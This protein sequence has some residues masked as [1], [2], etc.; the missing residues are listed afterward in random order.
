MT[1]TELR[2]QL[3]Q[4]GLAD[5]AKLP[6][7]RPEGR[8]GY[9]AQFRWMTVLME[10]DA[11]MALCGALADRR[12]C[13]VFVLWVLA[14]GLAGIERERD[15][16]ENRRFLREEHDQRFVDPEYRK[17][18]ESKEPT[19]RTADEAK[20]LELLAKTEVR[21]ATIVA[22]IAKR[23]R[24]IDLKEDWQRTEDDERFLKSLEHDPPP[25]F[26]WDLPAGRPT[27]RAKMVMVERL[28]QHFKLIQY[29]GKPAPLLETA[30]LFATVSRL[31][32]LLGKPDTNF[33]KAVSKF[34]DRIKQTD[35]LPE[36][37]PQRYSTLKGLDGFLEQTASEFWSF[38]Q[39][40]D[41]GLTNFPPPHP[42][43]RK[44]IQTITST[45]S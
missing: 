17:M 38:V 7:R 32:D 20:F 6:D 37:D 19:E 21:M 12:A 11:I 30:R 36:I 42:F 22:T 44:Y 27:Q 1:P 14:M 15:T 33:Q 43:T 8:V 45:S 25:P 23:K 24:A 41:M 39:N 4:L 26:A 5:C 40:F 2:V 34:H 9:P 35:L 16:A 31:T 13:V 29:D 28:Y 3:Q 18:I 10:D